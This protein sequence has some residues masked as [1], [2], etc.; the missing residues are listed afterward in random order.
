MNTRNP[1]LRLHDILLA[2]A[3]FCFTSGL[4]FTLAASPLAGF[5]DTTQPVMIVLGVA[6][7][8]YGVWL[9]FNATRPV[10]RRGFTLFTVIADSVWVL[11]SVLLLVLPVF[12]FTAGAKWAIGVTAI[13]VDMFATFQFLQWRGM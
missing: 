3:T 11:F 9:G 1:H 12:D 13:C 2:N 6:L 8:F 10:I 7:M 4:I 5:L